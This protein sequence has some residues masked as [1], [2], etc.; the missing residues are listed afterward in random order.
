VK[1]QES[2]GGTAPGNA[3]WRSDAAAPVAVG[4]GRETTIYVNPYTGAVLGEGAKSWRDFFH[5]VTELHRWLALEGEKRDIGKAITGAC[6]LAFLFIVL[7][8]I[9]LWWPQQWRW[10]AIKAVTVFDRRLKGKARDWNWHNVLGFWA[11][12]PLLVI[13]TTG[14]VMSYPWANDLLF[15]LAGS[16]PPPRNPAGGPGG[17]GGGGGR[18]GEGGKGALNLAS[19]DRMAARA[20]QQVPGWQTISWRQPGSFTIDQSHRG[21]PDKRTMLTLDP[22]TGDIVKDESCAKQSRGRQ[23]RLWSRWLHTGE[24]GGILGQTLAGFAALSAT[25]L[26]YTGLALSLRR[27][28]AWRKKARTDR[29]EDGMVTASDASPVEESMTV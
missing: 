22:K 21:R 10:K 2:Q 27:L 12:L 13:V 16:E 3:T 17:P 25:V 6:S 15:R 7:S 26:V 1:A 5:F 20:E 23:W 11:S 18:R 24:A 28:A 8:G 19:I 9:Y 14:A 29:L 4:F